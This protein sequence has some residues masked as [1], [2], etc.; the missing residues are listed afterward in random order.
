MVGVWF[1]F[2]VYALICAHDRFPCLITVVRTLYFK[3]DVTSSSWGTA[4]VRDN[5]YHLRVST[6][7]LRRGRETRG[8]PYANP[9]ACRYSWRSNQWPSSFHARSTRCYHTFRDLPPSWPSTITSITSSRTLAG[10]SSS[11]DASK[12][13]RPCPPERV[14]KLILRWDNTEPCS[15]GLRA[16]EQHHLCDIRDH[17]NQSVFFVLCFTSSRCLYLGK[18]YVFVY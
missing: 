4:S 17:I 8:G 15:E 5:P 3:W 7:Q 13:Q 18:R 12:F 2:F 14:H 16:A 10:L 1:S 11:S 6:T 9:I